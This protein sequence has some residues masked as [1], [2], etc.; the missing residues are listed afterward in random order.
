M[1]VVENSLKTHSQACV[2]AISAAIKQVNIML[3]HIIG[4]RGLEKLF[5]YNLLIKINLLFIKRLK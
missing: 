1:I 2:D 3:R 4:Q 5:K